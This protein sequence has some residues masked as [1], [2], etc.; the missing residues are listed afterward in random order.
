MEGK[1]DYTKEDFITNW[2]EGGYIETWDGHRYNWSSEIHQLILNQIGYN[3]DKDVLEIGCGAGYWT[4][5]L[6]EHSRNVTAI[7]LIPKPSINHSNFR[8]IENESLQ[9][10]CNTLEDESI[11]FAFSFGVF[12][13]F[14]IEACELYLQDVLRVLR[15]GG[16]AIFFYSD[17]KGMQEFEKDPT[18]TASLTYGECNNYA[19]IMPMIRKY[20]PDC[21]KLLEFRDSLVLITKR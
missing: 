19:D 14:S 13:H 3:K 21:K 4:N 16:T 1:K 18:I 10:N 11:D 15:T 12:C 17:D 5:F 7:D 9:F 8:Y 20:D 6:C 2:G